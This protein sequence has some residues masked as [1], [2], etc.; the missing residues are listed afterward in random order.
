MRD[1]D[2]HLNDLGQYE[3]GQTGFLLPNDVRTV[4]VARLDRL[5]HD[6]REVVQTASVLG[7]EFEERVLKE[8]PSLGEDLDAKIEVASQ[9]AIWLPLGEGR[10]RFNHMLLRD[11]AY[12]IH[13][14]A[15]RMKLHKEACPDAGA[16]FQG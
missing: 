8:M 4:L 14:R 9:A 1:N 10:Y 15:G 5:S 3:P 2:L 16:S 11:A 13:L 12:D 7:R 6:V